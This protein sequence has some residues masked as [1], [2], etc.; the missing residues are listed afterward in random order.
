MEELENN[1]IDSTKDG[2]IKIIEQELL[3]IAPELF[4]DDSK[5]EK[6]LAL[7]S[8]TMIHSGPIP[9]PETL[10]QYNDII[11]EGAERIMRMAENQQAHRIEMEKTVIRRQSF[12]SLLGQIFG[13]LIGI[14]GISWGGYLALHGREWTGVTIAG[15]TVISLVSVFVIGK[16]KK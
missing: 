10:Q 2:D 6:V 5:K 1:D 12:Q 14:L 9:H 7:V 4:Q 3:E 11:P 15:G 16:R 8:R 13:F